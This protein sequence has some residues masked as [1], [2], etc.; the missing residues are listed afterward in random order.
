MTAPARNSALAPFRVRSYRFQWPADVLTSWAFEM[1]FLILGWYILVETGS[2]VVLTFFGS[3]MYLGTL[4]APMFGVFGDRIGHRNLLAG[5]RAAYAVLATTM[6]VLALTGLLNPVYVFILAAI[7]GVIRPSDLGVRGAL[8]AATM[9]H[10]YL[11]SAMSVSRTTMDSARIAGA[12]TGAGMFATLGMGPAYIA[13]ASLYVLSTILT[14]CISPAAETA[15]Q[16]DTDSTS[17]RPSPWRDLSE[18]LAYIWNTPR[19]QA[20]MWIAFLVNLTAYPFTG[21]LLPYIAR[22]VHQTDQT[23]LG[24]LSASFAFGALAASMILSNIGG[25]RLARL[26]I[27]STVI[28]YVLLILF[29]HMQTMPAAIACLMMAGFAQSFSMITL[30]VILLRTAGE[31]FRGRVMGVRMMAIYSL[32]IGLLIAGPMIERLGFAPTATLYA[33]VGL[34]FTLFIAVRWREDLWRPLAPANSI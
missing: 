20:A 28:W 8:V 27:T 16:R 23:G 10:E 25:V 30:A 29:A 31:R 6:L 19:M 7:F 22:N 26:M 2:V 33:A 17:A 14:L 4:V 1:E 32:P 13:I 34:L 11:V 12:L 18:G 3:L 5:M 24:Y 9:P 21:N 15:P